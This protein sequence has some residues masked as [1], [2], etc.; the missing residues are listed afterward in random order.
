M[1]CVAAIYTTPS[2]VDANIALFKMGN[3]IAGREP[4]PT[5]YA[6]GRR[7]RIPA[8]YC[9]LVTLRVKVARQ[10][11]AYLSSSA[12]D[13]DFH[14]GRYLCQSADSAICFSPSPSSTIKA[15]GSAAMSAS[16]EGWPASIRRLRASATARKTRRAWQAL[17]LNRVFGSH[18]CGIRPSHAA[19]WCTSRCVCEPY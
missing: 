4:I 7:L 1:L 13:D 14:D 10:H 6:P 17:S 3:P 15:A 19:L 5:N 16:A 11:L 8:E 18:G 9:H 12:W 2:E